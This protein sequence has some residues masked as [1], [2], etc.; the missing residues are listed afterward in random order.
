MELSSKPP[1]NLPTFSQN[2]PE[3]FG[4]FLQ[5][6]EP[7]PEPG[8]LPNL[9]RSLSGTCPELSR[10]PNSPPKPPIGRPQRS[11]SVCQTWLKRLLKK[12]A[13][14][15]SPNTSIIFE[16]YFEIWTLAFE[17]GASCNLTTTTA[18]PLALKAPQLFAQLR[19]SFS[20]CSQLMAFLESTFKGPPPRCCQVTVNTS[21]PNST[22]KPSAPRPFLKHKHN[23]PPKKAFSTI[24]LP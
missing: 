7:S 18:L 8:T 4:I 22:S 20:S 19:K 16:K 17:V 24:Q 21:R 2:V 12:D 9:P 5:P 23:T 14:H 1:M 6:A 15:L 3:P 13:Q 10:N 11:I